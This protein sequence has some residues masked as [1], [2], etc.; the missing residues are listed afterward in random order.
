M[1]ESE[2]RSRDRET[3]RHRK[4]EGGGVSKVR[5][6]QT[7]KAWQMSCQDGGGRGLRI[8]SGCLYKRESGSRR[9]E[10]RK[11]REDEIAVNFAACLESLTT[12]GTSR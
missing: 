9:I 2:A 1:P 7:D 8:G 4:V 3:L 6:C 5:L 10:N 12:D 11:S